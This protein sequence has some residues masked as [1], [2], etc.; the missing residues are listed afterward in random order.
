MVYVIVGI[1]LIVF[2]VYLIRRKPVWL[3]QITPSGKEL[4]FCSHCG[5]IWTP[6]YYSEYQLNQ[7]PSE[8]PQ[9]HRKMRI[10][11]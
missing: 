9:C 6:I 2:L 5:Y 3:K 10:E 7:P 11:H 4:T 1:L 8:C